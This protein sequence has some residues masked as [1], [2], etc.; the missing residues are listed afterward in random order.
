MGVIADNAGRYSL[1]TQCLTTLRSPV[2]TAVKF[3]IGSD[4]SVGRNNL[5]KQMIEMG[6]EWILFLDDD[7][8]FPP[9]ILMR[10]LGTDLDVVGALYCQRALP[11]SPIAYSAKDPD[12]TYKPLFLP[13]LP[14]DEVVQVRA[15]GTGGMLIRAEVLH[16]M[17]YPWFQ[18]TT[19]QSEDLRFCDQLDAMGI[20]VHVH[21]GVRL[22]HLSPSA[23]WPAHDG[24]R[25]SIG[26]SLADQYS[27]TIGI[28][29]TPTPE[30]DD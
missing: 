7:H 2:N 12:G 8:V 15:L 6:G 4:R 27:I 18:H 3:A 17:E 24:E 28:D 29:E 16:A 19:E 26:F 21:T 30:A 14:A 25:W 13:H 10:L 20:P 23:V 1:F 11:F 5:V 22:G 9:S